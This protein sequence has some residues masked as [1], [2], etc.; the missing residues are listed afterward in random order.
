MGGPEVVDP[1]PQGL[2]YT[3]DNYP[4]VIRFTPYSQDEVPVELYD[5]ETI[6]DEFL[7]PNFDIWII[8]QEL[9]P[10]K[11]YHIYIDTHL[12]LNEVKTKVRDFI[13]PYYPDRKRGF[14]TAQFNV[15]L[16]TNPLQA[17]IYPFKQHGW[18]EFSGFEENFIGKCINLAF[19]KK[20]NDV[21][22]AIAALAADFHN[23]KIQDP[24]EFATQLSQVY[25]ENDRNLNYKT[26][27]NYIN[28]KI[29]KRDPSKASYLAKKNLVFH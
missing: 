10:K 12:N 14:G 23:F 15:Q 20:T 11:H 27:Q 4:Y 3:P 13:Y 28:S 16:S 17:C 21:E 7:I 18:Y 8:S 2:S 24:Y 26:L 5:K 19:E 9:V 6:V 29:I 25:A 1:R 22:K